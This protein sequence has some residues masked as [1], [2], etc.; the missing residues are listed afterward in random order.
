VNRQRKTDAW[1]P[2]WVGDYLADTQ[3][4]TRDQ[5]GAYLLLLMAYWRNGGPLPDDDDRLAAIV[6]ASRKE[7][8]LLRP[9]VVEFF[10]IDLGVWRQKRADTELAVSARR[11][12]EATTK[13]SAAAN[14]R[15]RRQD[16][17]AQQHAPSNACSNAPS[18][19]QA[20]LE[21]CPPPSPSPTTGIPADVAKDQN[22]R[23]QP[24]RALEKDQLP[25]SSTGG[26]ACKAMRL[27]G[28]AD[29][30]PSHP[31]LLALL[32][33]GISVSE[34]VAAAE[35]AVRNG[36]G[37]AYALA[38]AEGRRRDAAAVRVLPSPSGA[39]SDPDTRASLVHDARRL[40]IGEWDQ[41]LEQFP[42]FAARVR[43]ARAAEQS[44]AAA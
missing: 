37:F 40:G 8:K 39:L 24:V 23:A 16:S 36:K 6:K 12:A 13:A 4:L 14:A 44:R 22:Q 38:A 7:W 26:E 28:L 32:G 18:T 41:T 27:A 2:L 10:N 20:V 5:H 3:H 11:A 42:Q 30:N 25:I 43:V 21:L 33:Q 19:P 17:G 1:M 29:A 31:K 15:W 9:A 35:T 34:L